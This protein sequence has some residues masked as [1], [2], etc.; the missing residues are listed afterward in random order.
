MF[1]KQLEY[2]IFSIFY[3]KSWYLPTSSAKA[4][5]LAFVSAEEFSEP[6]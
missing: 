4:L 3:D 1:R 6:M 5:A 2:Q